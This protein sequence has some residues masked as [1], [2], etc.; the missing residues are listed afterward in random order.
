MDIFEI[1]SRHRLRFAYKGTLTVEDLWDLSKEDLD[2][3][4]KNLKK[5]DDESQ[6]NG[7]LDTPSTT[8]IDVKLALQIVK[9]IF[10]VKIEEENA[11][12]NAAAKKIRNQKILEL[13]EKK[14]D[15]QLEEKT[16]EELTAMLDEN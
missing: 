3:I 5:M 8:D 13:I 11:R 14:S 6:T 15:N 7:L 1:A 16:I 9:R 2:I 12:K 4:Y 10:D